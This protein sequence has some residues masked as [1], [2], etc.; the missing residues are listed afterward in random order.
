MHKTQNLERLVSEFCRVYFEI[1]LEKGQNF[2]ILGAKKPKN[3]DKM[4]STRP[5]CPWPTPAFKM[6]Q[7]CR[8]DILDFEI[9]SN[10]RFLVVFGQIRHWK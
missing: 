7:R 2:E 9:R 8:T 4:V 5:L 10:W 6:K 3:N 1:F